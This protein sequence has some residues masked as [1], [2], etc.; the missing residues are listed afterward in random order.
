MRKPLIRA[1]IAAILISA[2]GTSIWMM[3]LR[4]LD[5]D[6][7][8]SIIGIWTLNT[9][10]SADA[11]PIS[12][13]D[14]VDS[15]TVFLDFAFQQ[16][17]FD[18]IRFAYTFLRPNEITFWAPRWNRSYWNIVYDGNQLALTGVSAFGWP[19]WS[20]EKGSFK[21]ESAA[22]WPLITLLLA[23]SVGGALLV[24]PPRSKMNKATERNVKGS[25]KSR[26]AR[27][28]RSILLILC[29]MG[30]FGLGFLIGAVL[31]N[32]QIVLKV[33]LPWDAV[34]TLE[35]SLALLILG[36]RTIGSNRMFIGRFRIS[37]YYFGL[38]LGGVG[39][40][41]FVQSIFALVA[42]KLWGQ[43]V[44]LSIHMA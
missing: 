21:K 14:F 18:N 16:Q 31:W 22:T 26:S 36:F 23:F 34:I 37:W 17:K 27:F 8:N 13:M 7:E 30:V 15:K 1:S 40:Y 35:L 42:L 44:F 29:S 4:P 11:F 12:G 3:S 2:I 38:I 28:L 32:S 10:L 41:G 24:A 25:T 20:A 39:A 5:S 9:G 6:Q 19:A 33:W 43:Y